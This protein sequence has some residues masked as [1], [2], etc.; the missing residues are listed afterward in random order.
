[1]ERGSQGSEVILGT[2]APAEFPLELPHDLGPY[3]GE[4]KR[5][6]AEPCQLRESEEIIHTVILSHSS[7]VVC[8]VAISN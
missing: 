8:K 3:P 5:C 4:Q 7:V 2:P 6:P 1:M